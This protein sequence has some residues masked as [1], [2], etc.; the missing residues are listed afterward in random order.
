MG[1]VIEFPSDKVYA[2]RLMDALE[3]DID[4]LDEAYE[5]L[6]LMHYR[7]HELEQYCNKKEY[8]FDFKLAR[9]ADN[10]GVENV[11]VRFLGYTTRH[12]IKIDA[13]NDTYQL[14]LFNGEWGDNDTYQLEL[15]NGEWEDED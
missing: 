4:E 11:P 2:E 15:F 7:M 1:K 12:S 14:E 9:Y 13:D 3:R 8:S 6:D 10:V 5:K